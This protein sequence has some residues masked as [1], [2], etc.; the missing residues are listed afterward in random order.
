MDPR[1]FVD[2]ELSLISAMFAIQKVVKPMVVLIKDDKR[3]AVPVYYQNIAHKEIVAQG[4]KDLVKNS[5]PDVVIY[6]AE[7]RTKIIQGITSE[8]PSSISPHDPQAWEIVNVQ[9]EFRTGEKFGCDAKI[10][11]DQGITRLEK[12]E[13]HDATRSIGRFADFF[14]ITKKLN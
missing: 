13:V 7:A 5:E 14:P 10:N 4:I 6:M 8:L 3:F 11:R 12:F 1:E 2:Q 9:I